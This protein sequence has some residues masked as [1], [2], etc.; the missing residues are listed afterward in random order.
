MGASGIE[1]RIGVWRREKRR[2]EEEER[3]LNRAVIDDFLRAVRCVRVLRLID[4]RTDAVF[5]LDKV[6]HLFVNLSPYFVPRA[7]ALDDRVGT[8]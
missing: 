7:D 3:S 5:V 6:S 2:E 4:V 1:W 8:S